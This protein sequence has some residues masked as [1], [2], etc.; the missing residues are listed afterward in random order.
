M[1]ND[2]DLQLNISSRESVESMSKSAL[3]EMG[4]ALTQI[5]GKA[6]LYNPNATDAPVEDNMHTYTMHKIGTGLYFAENKSEVLGN[7]ESGA[8][9]IPMGAIDDKVS[10]GTDNPFLHPSFNPEDVDDFQRP[11]DPA[12]IA[13]F[14]SRGLLVG[15][16]IGMGNLFDAAYRDVTIGKITGMQDPGIDHSPPTPIW[17]Q[18]K[19]H[20][21]SD[22]NTE[23]LQIQYE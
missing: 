10:V 11:V 1:S 22:H 17:E 21:G 5:G 23:Q 13:L 6:I 8:E 19:Q 9:I 2:E 18:C 14:Q 12:V 4:Y 16:V 3:K 20:P 7:N 15:G